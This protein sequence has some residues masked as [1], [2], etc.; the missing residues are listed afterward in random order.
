M[1]VIIMLCIV[2][3]SLMILDASI[4]DLIE[5]PKNK[6]VFKFFLLL[7]ILLLVFSALPGIIIEQPDGIYR[8]NSEAHDLLTRYKE[9]KTLLG[10]SAFCILILMIAMS[11]FW[12]RMSPN[13]SKG[14]MFKFVIG[15]MLCGAFCLLS[16][17]PELVIGQRPRMKNTTS[18]ELMIS[19]LTEWSKK[20]GY[21]TSMWILPLTILVLSRTAFSQQIKRIYNLL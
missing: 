6:G 11:P 19:E 16:F 7:S 2:G 4:F 3:I 15:I 17:Y 14:I 21:L 8:G 18:N 20:R 10:A 5:A 12:Y 9:Q 13:L 1:W